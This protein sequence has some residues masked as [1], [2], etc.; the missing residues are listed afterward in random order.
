MEF[1]GSKS[2]ELLPNV[3]LRRLQVNVRHACE[4]RVKSLATIR[5][6]SVGSLNRIDSS[7]CFSSSIVEVLTVTRLD[8]VVEVCLYVVCVG[9]SLCEVRRVTKSKRIVTMYW[10]T[11]HE[12]WC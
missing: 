12:D 6:I 10:Y 5:R 2:H 11:E 3:Y 4:L 7:A 1:S 9:R 8:G